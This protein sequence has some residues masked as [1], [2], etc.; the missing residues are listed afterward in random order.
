MRPLVLLAWMSASACISVP[1]RYQSPVTRYR[2]MTART[3]AIEGF[4]VSSLQP[5]GCTTTTSVGSAFA[6]GTTGLY[7]GTGVAENEQ[8]V[9]S[10][11]E[12]ASARCSR[13]RMLPRG[14][15]TGDHLVWD[16]KGDSV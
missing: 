3:I 13:T 10:S 6:G 14:H 15:A 9:L 11:E 7:V 5:M 4:T 16:R 8:Y 1:A 12:E 2:P